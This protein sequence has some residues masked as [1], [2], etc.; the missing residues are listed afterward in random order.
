[1]VSS[2]SKT[3]ADI[4]IKRRQPTI[5]FSTSEQVQI[6]NAPGLET[7][8][9]LMSCI[10]TW[11]ER[12]I[13]RAV[14][15][16]RKQITDPQLLNHVN[17]LIAQEATHSHYHQNANANWLPDSPKINR[18]QRQLTWIGTTLIKYAPKRLLLALGVAMEHATSSKAKPFHD[19][20]AWFKAHL[21]PPFF[22]LWAWHIIEEIEHKSV[23]FD[24]YN[25]TAKSKIGAYCL[26]A[27]TLF[28][29]T[30]FIT[31]YFLIWCCFIFQEY[32]A[33]PYKKAPRPKHYWFKSNK[34]L[35]LY[36]AQRPIRTTFYLSKAIIPEWLNFFHP[37]FHPWKTCQRSILKEIKTAI[38][39]TT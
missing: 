10:I 34:K 12:I 21:N 27:A 38:S 32:K 16:Y 39:T 24:L 17:Q 6:P 19:N 22:K 11:G 30:L 28:F 7:Y 31:P 33:I 26:R 13:I 36:I 14:A 4:E 8:C 23:V 20:L 25:A 3:P 29:L 35:T 2:L 37:S 5:E 18:F 9:T 15:H 1:M